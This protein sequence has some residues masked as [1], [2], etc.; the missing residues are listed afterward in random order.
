MA[1]APTVPVTET[2]VNYEIETK[3]FYC[4]QSIITDK[5]SDNSSIYDIC[6]KT[7]RQKQT[8]KQ[9]DIQKTAKHAKKNQTNR[10]TDKQTNK[11]TDKKQKSNG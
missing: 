1:S 7:V 8:N 11:Q 2:A 3:I 4:C 10:Q 6:R 5:L 9:T